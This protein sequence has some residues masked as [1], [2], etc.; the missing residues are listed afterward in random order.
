[1]FPFWH[2]V[3]APIIEAAQARR[4]VEIGALRGEHTELMLERLGPGVELHVIDPVPAFD[5]A[6]HERR[7]PG[8]YVF[9]RDLSVNVL[10]HL[11]PMDV[12]LVD[13]DHNWYTVFTELNQLSQV[14]RDAGAPM[15]VAI[16]HDVCWPYGRRDLY[17]DP[18]NIPDEHKQ[19]WRRRGMRP[20]RSELLPGTGGLNAELANA[21]TEGGPRNGVMTAVEDFVAQYDRQL[22]L[23]VIPIYFGLAILAEEERLAAQ[24]AL[25]EHLDW[26][27]TADGRLRLLELSERVRLDGVVFDQAMFRNQSRRVETLAGRY[28]DGTKQLVVEMGNERSGS[29]ASDGTSADAAL[30]DL[31]EQL[32]RWWASA[33]PGDVAFA[34]R[35]DDSAV[36]VAAFL[37][38]HDAETRPRF[39]RRLL[40]GPAAHDEERERTASMLRRLDLTDRVGT[41]GE[42][43]GD[44]DAR[45]PLSLVVAGRCDVRTVEAIDQLYPRLSPG[46]AVVVAD[47]V[48]PAVVDALEKV[49]AGHGTSSPLERSAHGALHWRKDVAGAR[50]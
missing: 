4:I 29:P 7:F 22:R 37:E 40:L 49:R 16:L 36:F 1:M 43:D 27:Q 10:P 18:S 31:H 32:A 12:A 6:E 8:R 45:R 9:H 5:P 48:D 13:G 15:P 25:A 23:V 41:L 42:H 19:P 28:L 47:P 38:A 11:E 34:G 2:D 3:V 24:P 33:T 50:S 46:G 17:Y 39:R 14:A 35:A 30:D 44:P 21:V 20:G 26:L